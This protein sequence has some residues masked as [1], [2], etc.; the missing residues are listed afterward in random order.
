MIDNGYIFLHRKLL[1]APEWRLSTPEQKSVFITI[2]LMA[3]YEANKWEWNGNEFDIK[4]G[5]F[6]TSL[7]S[8]RKAAGIG[9]SQQN[10]RTALN[11]FEK[12]GFLTNQSTNRGRLISIIKWDEYQIIQSAPNKLNNKPLTS[13][14]QAPNKLLT[15]IEERKK[16][17]KEKKEINYPDWLDLEVW[18]EFKNYRGNGKGKF[19]P[20]AQQLAI[21]K[22]EKLREEGNDPSEVIRRTIECGWSGLFPLKENKREETLDEWT[23]RVS[24]T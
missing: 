19:T 12:L 9:I 18:K 13:S 17:K 16:Y 3:N 22:L 15:P 14:S 20:Y 21:N 4:P 2:L 24:Q 10:V 7:D 23:K 11:R 1:K 8:I 6:V 5:Q